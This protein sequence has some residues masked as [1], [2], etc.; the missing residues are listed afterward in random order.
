LNLSWKLRTVQPHPL[1]LV[2]CLVLHQLLASWRRDH[3]PQA[4]TAT[5]A[6]SVHVRLFADFVIQDIYKI[7]SNMSN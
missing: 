7:D 3:G 6:G 2:F 4:L 5:T 1:A